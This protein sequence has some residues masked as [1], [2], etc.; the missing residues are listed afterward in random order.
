MQSETLIRW[1]S[2]VF[3]LFLLLVPCQAQLP[4]ARPL[5]PVIDKRHE[6]A[7]VKAPPMQKSAAADRLR[8]SVPS[9]KVE[10]EPVTGSAKSVSST[11]GFLT[12]REGKGATISAASLAGFSASDPNRVTK[13]FL[14]EHRALFGHGAEALDKARV[15][16]D[17]VAPNNQLHTV[18]WEQQVDGIAVFEGV[19]ISH[20]TR[21]GELVKISSQFISDPD[22]AATLGT[23]NRAA[24]VGTP[25]LAAG[26]AVTLAA[27]NVEVNLDEKNVV[28]TSPLSSG[29]EQRQQFK[30]PGLKGETEAKLI[31]LPMSSEKLRLCWD[32]VLM[33]RQ[34]GEMFRVLLDAESGEVLVRRCLTSY[35]TD[36]TYNVYTSDS[37]SPFSPGWPTP[38]TNQPPYVSRTL[39][40]L[41]AMDTN[42]SPAGWI[43]DGGN[44]TWGNNVDA[45]TDRNADDIADLP[46]PQG[47]PFRVFDF[48]MNLTT[49]DPTNYS[50]AA[51]VQLFY[52]CNWYHDQLYALGFTE[53]AGNFQS[54]NFAR[55][56]LGNDAVQA[57]AQDGSGVNNANFSTPPDGSAGRMQMF[58]FSGPSP[59]RDGDLDAEIV[60][61]EHTHGLSWRLVG[62]GQALGDT[63]SDGLGEGWSDFYGL[64]LLSQAGDDVNGVYAAGGYATFRLSG[65]M[66]NYYFGIR[67]YPYTTDMSKN[68]L[69]FKD[70]DPVQASTHT[71]VPRSPIIGN[72][73]NEVHNE[74]EV[75][76]IT[77]WEVHANLVNKYGWA[78]GNQLALQLVTD[79]MKLTVAH[80]NFLQAR[81]SILQADL[82]DSGG[83]NRNE[84]WAAFAKRG[85]GFSATSPASSTTT[86]LQESFD[87]PDDLRISPAAGLS[88][89][90]TIGGPLNPACRTFTLYNAGTNSLNWTALVTQSWVS[91]SSDGGN[92]SVGDSNTVN[93][94]LTSAASALPVGTYATT[95]VF[96]NLTSGVRATRSVVL[97]VVPPTAFTFTL[98]ADPGW[99]RQ[100]EWNFGRPSGSGGL[101][102]GHPDPASGATGSNV[103]GINLSGDYSTNVGGSYYL[104]AGPINCSAFTTMR[105][106]FQRWLNTDYQP[107]VYA[108]LEIS[109][110]GS[111][112]ANIWSNGTSEV[113]DTAWTRV[114]YD[115]SAYADTQ[116][117]VYLRWG[118]RV[119]S[120][121]AWAYSGWNLDDIALLGIPTAPLNVILP[122]TTAENSGVLTNGGSM[123]LAS[124]LPTNVVVSLISSAPQRLTVPS[125]VTIQAGQLS[126]LFDLSPIDNSL[127]DGN[128]LVTI[129]AS[130]PG[131]TNI[132][133][134]ILVVDDDIAPLITSQPASRTVTVSGTATFGISAIGAAP[135]SYF[136]MRN[137]TLI[138]GATNTT[139]TTNNVQLT[140]T[141]SQFSCLASNIYGTAAS[142]NA[143]LTVT[144]DYFAELFGTTITNLAFTTYTFTPNGSANFY[145]VCA[146]SA[147]A[148]PTSPTGGTALSLTDDS[149]LPIT[150]SGSNTVAIYNTR[151]NV[152]YIGSNGYLTMTAGDSSYLPSYLY[153]FTLPRIAAVYR[154]LNPGSGGTVTWKQLSDRVAVT[155]LAVPI[156]GSA[157]VTNSFQIELFFDGRIQLTYLKLN[158]PSGLVGLSAGTGQPANFVASDF[159][160]YTTCSS[161]PPLIILQPQSQ[162]VAVGATASFAIS[163]SGSLPLS[164]SWQRNGF[165]I[166]GAIATS[167]NLTN[168]QYSDSGSQFSCVVTNVSGMTTSAVATLT[169]NVDHFGWSAISSP[170]L[171]NSPFSGTITAQDVNNQI[172]TNFTGAVALSGAAG[173]GLTTNTILGSPI[174]TSSSIGTW[175]LGYAFTPGTNL[176]VT[177]VRHY[178]GTKV[179]IWNDSGTLLASQTVSSVP[180]AWVETPLA[181]PLT[182]TAGVRYRVATYSAGTTYYWRTDLPNT[183]PN[184]IINQSYNSSAD[185]F[186]TST[187]S[188]V[189]WLVGLRYTVGSAYP[190]AITPT[191]TGSFTGGVW[192]GNL[193][194]LQAA[195]NVVLIAS[196]V[197]GHAGSSNPFQVVSNSVITQVAVLSDGNIQITLAGS[198]GD[199]YRV[200]GST[201]LLDWQTIASV[202]NLTGTVQFTD[203]TSTNYIR[204]FYRLV[205][206]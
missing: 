190:I 6:A 177:H 42:A 73:A 56:G 171:V 51:V 206:P 60:F 137:S 84:L 184:G 46:R 163:A 104:T 129:T 87:L 67:R 124:A 203:P 102:H 49:Q 166:S 152:I 144:P 191:N 54:N 146:Q 145:G 168:A 72:T 25:A 12:G 3:L 79:G 26:H 7:Q 188:A 43:N 197:L 174:Y 74:G 70:I 83:T 176:T 180:G 90:G 24:L 143:V 10:F 155:Y 81:D 121:G 114:S 57:D 1:A 101:S 103:F 99:S 22:A 62:G 64:S 157:T 127:Q 204:R 94:C 200:L 20:T 159:T 93:V 205:M 181:T 175:T 76:C 148:F 41:P 116:P 55:G 48:P 100:G 125:T 119:A 149:F 44:E 18:V 113:A 179:S 195:T 142:S 183:F 147:I 150:L 77:L 61:H 106:Q 8:Q 21:N 169:V 202:T 88:S 160:T 45:H 86:G 133:S 158:T 78:I 136:W 122:G 75:W 192:T 35:L 39:V 185:G 107:F 187:D 14:N 9:L 131:F 30:A 63:Q 140:D 123:L 167:Y 40:T 69:T 89:S 97:D 80:P 82:V 36:A 128:Q 91:V 105:L 182:L 165:P 92:L 117:G 108:T 130:A 126:G 161:Q 5:L 193:I 27:Q 178:F 4:P 23:P 59:R 98:D 139:Y 29:A 172:V 132:S 34:R 151:T 53:A 16:R 13:A 19:L 109:T 17:Y 189:W 170:Q 47:S 201:N 33:N 186:P 118:H 162:T 199:V 110:N 173:G 37:P 2:A 198:S 68:P 120:A 85:M 15:S 32:V 58:I 115:I 112:W 31:W 194:V 153:H 156:Y 65:S 28:A 38:N 50:S 134:T 196:D 95:V 52:L 138:A 164:Y 154:D 11:D 135:L 141:G 71:G 111:T 96:S 66:T